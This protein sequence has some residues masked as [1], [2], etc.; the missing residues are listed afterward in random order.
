MLLKVSS[1]CFVVLLSLSVNNAF[2]APHCSGGNASCGNHCNEAAADCN[3]DCCSSMRQR[4]QVSESVLSHLNAGAEAYR[5]GYFE[6]AANCYRYVL[7]EDPN[8]REAL[9]R[10]GRLAELNGQPE[11]AQYFYR[12][13]AVRDQLYTSVQTPTMQEPCPDLCLA[14]KPSR[15][16]GKKLLKFMARAGAAVLNAAASSGG[17]YYGYIPYGGGFSSMNGMSL[18]VNAMEDT[19][20]CPVC[21]ALR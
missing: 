1:L 18:G 11:Q 9:E 5:N 21:E 4:G 14:N 16:T 20:G 2:C 6:L 17:G 19:D 10:V 12:L 3:S 8:N 7:E 13:A 15:K